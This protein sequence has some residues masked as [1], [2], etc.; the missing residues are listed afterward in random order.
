M[1]TIGIGIGHFTYLNIDSFIQGIEWIY[2]LLITVSGY[3]S[4]L[5]PV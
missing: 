4:N 3:I 1:D 5:I 2:A